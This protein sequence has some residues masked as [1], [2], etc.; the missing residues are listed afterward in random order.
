MSATLGAA[1][2]GE[3][4]AGVSISLL[5]ATIE[6]AK[7]F[8]AG[9]TIAAGSI[10]ATAALLAEETMRAM[11]WSK[12]KVLAATLLALGIATGDT[13]VLARQDTPQPAPPQTPAPGG[14]A[15]KPAAPQTD[16]DRL[17][18]EWRLDKIGTVRDFMAPEALPSSLQSVA[19][20]GNQFVFSDVNGDFT[21]PRSMTLDSQTDPKQITWSRTTISGAEDVTRGIYKIEDDVWTVC[22]NFGS[23]GDRPA[24]FD[25]SKDVFRGDL[26]TRKA[27]LIYHRVKNPTIPTG[28]AK[29]E[30]QKLQGFW[31]FV[32]QERDGQKVLQPEK[33]LLGDDLLI[34]GNKISQA[35]NSLYHYILRVNLSSTPHTLRLDPTPFTLDERLLGPSGRHSTFWSYQRDGET[36]AICSHENSDQTPPGELVTRPGDG[37]TLVVLHRQASNPTVSST[38]AVAKS[39]ISPDAKPVEKPQAEPAAAA[40]KN[41]DEDDAALAKRQEEFETQRDQLSGQHD[42]GMIE[43]DVLKEQVHKAQ[44][45]VIDP[46]V[47]RQELKSSPGPGD[48]FQRS[49]KDSE[50]RLRRLQQEYVRKKQVVEAQSREIA[51]MKGEIAAHGR[52]MP[53]MELPPGEPGKIHV[54]DTILVEVLEPLPGRPITG[55]RLVRPDGTIGLG[56]YGDVPAAGLTRLGLKEKIVVHLKKYLSD[57]QLGLIVEDPR[58]KKTVPV[59]PADSDRVFVDEWPT[60]QKGGSNAEARVGIAGAKNRGAKPDT[61]Q[62]GD[63]VLVEVLETLPGRP[64]SGEK[65]VRARWHHQSGLL[66]RSLRGQPHPPG[67]EG[68]DRHPPPE[69]PQ[70]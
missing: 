64:I 63:I 2:V 7:L 12:L 30:L 36:L 60:F 10:S 70:R 58:T 13:G 65:I 16:L 62:V 45:R 4:Q 38:E 11:M 15:P 53:D 1:L 37:R 61:I 44:T 17:Q 56:F 21:S 42:L 33:S 54:G 59:A 47:I 24:D 46:D 20:Q 51:R 43:L 28:A 22:Y 8:A 69:V 32:E 29:E 27:N 41:P 31:Q 39:Q 55:E 5:R 26:T 35:K 48:S 19:V 40:V 52:G 23:P 66:R 49:L 14:E 57:Q 6:A 50:E 34:A 18:G 9:K 25:T 3:A 68:E 67:V